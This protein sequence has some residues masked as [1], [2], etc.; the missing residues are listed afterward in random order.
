MFLLLCRVLYLLLHVSLLLFVCCCRHS[1]LCVS[2][3]FVLCCLLQLCDSQLQL[4]FFSSSIA[5]TNNKVLV[6][7]C[8][9]QS[10]L[11][12]LVVA[13]RNKRMQL[14]DVDNADLA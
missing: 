7:R 8:N 14:A 4:R 10:D 9:L 2:A 3:V 5:S 13:V 1:Q 6:A 11:T 12:D